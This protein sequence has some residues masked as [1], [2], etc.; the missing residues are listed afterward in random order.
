MRLFAAALITLC[1]AD[2]ALSQTDGT[3]FINF[4]SQFETVNEL[5]VSPSGV[6]IQVQGDFRVSTTSYDGLGG[7]DFLLFTNDS[8]YLRAGTAQNIEQFL[9]GSGNDVIDLS[10]QAGSTR[11][12]GGAGEDIIFGGLAGD[13]MLGAQNDDFLDGGAGNDAIEGNDGND[14]IFG[15]LNDDVILG[16]SGI[17]IIDAGDGSDLIGVIND[18]D[19]VSGGTG[20]DI[21]SFR[22]LATDGIVTIT[23]FSEDDFLN[24][25]SLLVDYDAVTDSLS[26][27]IQFSQVGND[28]H[29]ALDADGSATALGFFQI[30]LLEGVDVSRIVRAGADDWAGVAAASLGDSS[31]YSDL[32]AGGTVATFSLRPVPIPSAAVLLLSGLG[33]LRISRRKRRCFRY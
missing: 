18:G 15:G 9:A 26:D 32:L 8:D 17:D 3:D 25:F 30:G 20:A 13:T 33:L 2:S 21:F 12:T 10:D 23:D 1:L 11:A 5:R 16:G 7:V 6:A 27:F 19:I 22:T 29:V 28:V 14:T 31:R 24:F 4:L